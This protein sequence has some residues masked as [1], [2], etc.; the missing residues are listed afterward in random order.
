MLWLNCHT[1]IVYARKRVSLGVSEQR[2][3]VAQLLH[4]HTIN[5]EPPRQFPTLRRYFFVLSAVE[6]LKLHKGFK[7]LL[8]LLKQITA[9]REGITCGK[10]DLRTAF[11]FSSSS[12]I[13]ISGSAG[14]EAFK[15]RKDFPVYKIHVHPWLEFFSSSGQTVQKIFELW[16]RRIVIL[17]FLKVSQ[18]YLF[19][20]NN[21]SHF[22][23][24]KVVKLSISMH[25]FSTALFFFL[26]VFIYL[27][28]EINFIPLKE[29]IWPKFSTM[30]S[31]PTSPF[32]TRLKKW[33]FHGNAN[34]KHVDLSFLFPLNCWNLLTVT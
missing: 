9:V 32:K 29:S 1:S 26:A 22:S 20:E 10:F 28:G 18:V 3:R 16:I 27:T 33:T 2:L 25:S 30:V 19:S 21:R 12:C 24:C 31:Y 23:S 14:R 17:L 8:S 13:S 11:F 34:M 6:A 4:P 5:T 15:N 7:T